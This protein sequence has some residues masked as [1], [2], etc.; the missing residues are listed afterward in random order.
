MTAQAQ[1]M[2]VPAES[3]PAYWGP[4]DRYT[5]LVTGAQSGGAYFI[6][7]AFV[8]SA[9]GPPPH[10]HQREEKCFYL[11]AGQLTIMLGD[12]QLKVAALDLALDRTAP[13][14]GHPGADRVHE[15]RRATHWRRVCMPLKGG[16]CVTGEHQR[17]A[18]LLRCTSAGQH[19]CCRCV[20][21]PAD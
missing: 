2:H 1:N 12:R 13:A 6:L 4:G 11:L 17:S 19:W 9:G 14:A 15:R 21:R 18:V 3:G 10:I 7:Q 5:F 16:H 8:P 20:A